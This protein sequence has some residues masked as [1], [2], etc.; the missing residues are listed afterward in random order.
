[1]QSPEWLGHNTS[2]RSD[3]GVVPVHRTGQGV[4]GGG[5]APLKWGGGGVHGGEVGCVGPP[6]HPPSGGAEFLEA[7]KTPKKRFSLNKSALK[8]LEKSLDRPKARR[9]ILLPSAVHL[10]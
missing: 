5:G 6:P 2:G 8:A 4:G 10:E 7:P 3:E 9:K 1:M